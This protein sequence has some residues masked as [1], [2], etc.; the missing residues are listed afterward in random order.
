MARPPHSAIVD[1]KTGHVTPEWLDFLSRDAGDVS[2]GG[3]SSGVTIIKSGGG[4]SSGGGSSGVFVLDA[5]SLTGTTLAPN[6]INSSLTSVGRLTSGSLGPGFTID[7][8]SVTTLGSLPWTALPIGSGVWSAG[9]VEVT[10]VV[11]AQQFIG[12]GSSLTNL[13]LAAHALTHQAGG[14]DAI[15][16]DALS[17]PDDVLALNA[18]TGIHG[19]LPK[20]SGV[21]TQFL[22]GIGAW[23]EPASSGAGALAP[24]ASTHMP[25]G[26]DVL[27]LTATARVLGRVTAGAGPVEELTYLDLPETTPGPS[28][29]GVGRLHAVN[30]KGFT[31]LALKDTGATLY[32]TRDNITVAKVTG[33]AVTR[34]QLVYISGASGSNAEIQ[35]A[36]ADSWTT[37]PAIGWVLDA[38]AVNAFVRVLAAGTISGL[39]TSPWAEG[40][41]LFLS[42]QAAGAVTN[43]PPAYPFYTQRVG[44]V[45]RSH[46]TQGEVL[47]MLTAVLQPTHAPT[48]NTG[49]SDPITALDATVLTTGT[50]ADARLSINV[51]R[52]TGGYPSS[53]G[54]FLR[55]D[56]TWAIPSGGSGGGPHHTTHEPG[57]SDAIA[58][59]DGSVIT[60]GTVVDG[61]LSTNVVLK[62]GTNV[63]TGL[64]R[65]DS[66]WLYYEPA[67][68][69][70]ARLWSLGPN[71][72]TFYVSPVADSGAGQSAYVAVTR[73]GSLEASRN[74]SAQQDVIAVHG[75]FYGSG[76]GL[77]N[78]PAQNLITGP[79]NP[80]LIVVSAASRLL[81]RGDSG[82]GGM[83]EL[84][85]GFGLAITGTTL[86]VT[87]GGGS[88]GPHHTTHEP[89]GADALVGAA[90][91]AQ[92]NVFTALQ[93]LNSG[94]QVY[95]S[96]APVDQR[97]WSVEARADGMFRIHPLTDA[98]ADRP[99]VY[100]SI[101]QAGDLIASRDLSASSVN[102]SQRLQW[103]TTAT[104]PMLKRTGAG[105]EVRLGNDS[106]LTT[107]RALIDGGDLVGYV[108]DAR[109]TAN[110]LKVSGG[111]PGGTTTYL[112][113]DGTFSVPP[114]S[115]GGTGA[116][117]VSVGPDDPGGTF[118][119]WYDTDEPYNLQVVSPHASTHQPGGNDALTALD[120]GILTTGT[121][122]DARL[123]VNVLK[124]TGGYPGTTTVF[125]RGDGTFA[126]VT[127]FAPAAHATTHQPGGNDPLTALSASILTT[128]TLANARLAADI[129]VTGLVSAGTELR[130]GNFSFA[131]VATVDGSGQWG[132][133][134]NFNWNG[135]APIYDSTGG[136][137]GIGYTGGQVRFF[138]G[139]SQ[140]AGTAAPARM[141]IDASGVSV[142]GTMF[143]ANGLGATPL[144]ATNL[145]SGTVPDARFPATLPA[146]SG[147]N[148]TAL[149]ATQVTT[150]T[151]PDARLSANVQMKPIVATDLPAHAT[152][153][154]PGGAD[155][156][157]VDAVAATGSLRTL[158]TGAA[159]AAAGND[160]RFT[161]ARTPT[162]HATSHKSGGG[163]VIGLDTL[164]ATTDIT[165]LNA[166]AT[167]HGLLP[168]LS[169]TATQFLNGTGVW[170]SPAGTGDVVGPGVAVN[171][172]IAVFNGT[173][174][175][176]IKDGGKAL[177]TGAIV[178]DTDVQTLAGKTLTTPTIASF[179]NAVHTHQ[180]AAGG[181]TLAE[182]ALALTDVVTANASA[183]AH[184][185]L[186]KLSGTTTTFLRGDGTW[187]APSAVPGAHATTHQPGGAD[188][189]T[190]LS[191]TILTTGTLLN[192]RLDANVAITTSVAIGTNPATAGAIRLANNQG[193][194]ARNAANT[195]DT[196]IIQTDTG[197]NV[198]FGSLSSTPAMYFDC[199]AGISFRPVAGAAYY[200][201]DGAGFYPNTDNTLVIGYPTLRFAS[202]NFGGNVNAGGLGATPLNA[203]NLTTGTVPD[204][205]LSVNVL[206]FT[207]GYPGGTTTYL[208]A[209]GSFTVV[210][211]PAGADEVFIGTADPGAAYEIWFDTDEVTLDTGAVFG[212][213]S[214]VANNLPAYADATGKLLVDSGVAL[215]N[216]AK[217]NVANT[218]TGVVT[219]TAGLGTTP[220]NATNLT[221]GTVPNACFP[222][223]LPAASGVNLTAL[224]ATQLTSGT[225]PDARFPAT[226][227]AASGLNL[228]ALNATQLTTGT[229]ADARLSAN[230]ALLSA[231][232]WID[233]A[234]SATNFYNMTVDA[235]DQ[236][237][238]AYMLVGKTLFLDVYLDGVSVAAGLAQLWI[239]IPGGFRTAKKTQGIA[240]GFDNGV[241]T[242]IF[243]RVTPG[244]S[245]ATPPGDNW[246]EVGRSDVG[247][248]AAST[249]G[250][251][252]RV[253][254]NFPIV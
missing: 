26:A 225:V 200:N 138:A 183:L 101:N 62:N 116:D 114:G 136:I 27:T 249:N 248:W 82:A 236:I 81:G 157:V 173:T 242:P 84:S 64:N 214:A 86:S 212:P 103:G 73:S 99:T 134:Y 122:P 135:S 100:V 231:F 152:R 120:A 44:I 253:L 19:L 75:A 235:G 117:E 146:A 144:N 153:H 230:V 223:T 45:T 126:A 37:T 185:F 25:G 95:T 198:M 142:P 239:K 199:A 92:A 112:R 113:A 11:K 87:G 160:A 203:T 250:T 166:S 155:A 181:G 42:T 234:Y 10:G 69:V 83:Q 243:T 89:G 215:A 21:A 46:A 161:D 124:F 110:V 3:G 16:L 121:L 31:V 252:I 167:A 34:G 137:G 52:V 179:V 49:G 149:N 15:K 107:L 6:V 57:G 213:V 56:G 226:L 174:G 12:D 210:A 123:T 90:W 194:F 154:Q 130:L 168:K 232:S 182:A 17:A 254:M 74:V 240:L 188:P 67:Q 139:A 143:A 39:D 65:S 228:T 197:N 5:S 70:D 48:H 229:V 66:G 51:L 180:N 71:G 58:A 111:F 18:T 220:L 233:V 172:N 205:R 164:G 88:L 106:A 187:T 209:D 201:L 22:N 177:P 115:G 91:T 186:P 125:L 40:E 165:T 61:R 150:G 195:A 178:G 159:Q 1:P 35:L 98:G 23:T 128:G 14:S 245:G 96:A 140:P 133:G 38:G 204:A 131:R 4:G 94:L 238:Y 207:G 202:A 28:A 105:V 60:T 33:T 50:L 251:Y 2:S 76:V 224:N 218:F 170:S 79:I 211:L 7:L 77:T 47:V 78:I 41:R 184:G 246:V 145:T 162:A 247:N 156:M 20:L 176:L 192:A 68:P 129:V 227:P 54:V 24:H 217:L 30:Y 151:I 55:G 237:T 104:D 13:P 171:N 108:P 141:T 163:D 132:G 244:T 216:V 63:F 189:L 119:V 221:T 9:K 80:A 193:I 241:A 196:P 147:V 8:N 127:G 109:L 191:A 118:E 53:T 190:A 102:L 32:M 93:R 219:V 29:T 59:L 43:S 158:G 175:K 169:N 85:I 97:L 148:L 36:K 208:R 72:G 206:K 222:A